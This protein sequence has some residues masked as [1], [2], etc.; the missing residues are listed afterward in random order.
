MAIFNDTEKPPVTVVAQIVYTNI[1]ARS[2][3]VAQGGDRF[4]QGVV[5]E[6]GPD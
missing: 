5:N 6:F 1:I 3:N 4:S 2:V